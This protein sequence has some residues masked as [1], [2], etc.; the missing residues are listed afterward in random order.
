MNAYRNAVT[1]ILKQTFLIF[2]A[3]GAIDFIQ[4]TVKAMLSAAFDL[5]HL[6]TFPS[7]W[8]VLQSGAN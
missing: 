2:S 4:C 5:L 3:T 7:R 8:Q 1:E 6:H